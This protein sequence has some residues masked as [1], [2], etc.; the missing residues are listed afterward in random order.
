MNMINDIYYVFSF[1]S[2]DNIVNINSNNAIQNKSMRFKG[3]YNVYTKDIN[4]MILFFRQH[5]FDDSCFDNVLTCSAESI[6]DVDILDECLLGTYKLKSNNTN[7][8]YSI[9]TTLGILDTLIDSFI[10]D[11]AKTMTFGPAILRDDIEIVN[12]VSS[13]LYKIP[14]TQV[15]ERCV[16]DN[17]DVDSCNRFGEEDGNSTYPDAEYEHYQFISECVYDATGHYDTSIFTIEAYSKY[18]AEEMYWDK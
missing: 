7:G 2:Y 1:S 10:C 8:V 16:G 9:M 3:F 4:D 13:L 5:G 17:Q 15:F 18:F 14:H 12:I 6:E 11:Y